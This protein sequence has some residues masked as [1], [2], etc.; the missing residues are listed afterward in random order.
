MD[1]ITSV[2]NFYQKYDNGID[3]YWDVRLGIS[4][5]AMSKLMCYANV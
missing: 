4:F 1:H 2:R 5:M 3:P